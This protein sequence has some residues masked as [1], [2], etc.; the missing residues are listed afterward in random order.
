MRFRHVCIESL[1][2]VLPEESW[3]SDQIEER[4]RPLYER[5][6]LPVGRLELMTGIKARRM[7]PTGMRPSDASAAAGRA[8]LQHSKFKAHEIEAFIHCAVSRDMLEPATASFAHHK[9]GLGPHT[10]IFDLSNACLG[11]LNGL[12]TLGAMI[13][14]GQ[15]RCGMVVSGE[16]GRPL[17]EQTIARLLD[18]LLSRNDIKPFFA[19][20]TIGSGSVA[21]VVCHENLLPAGPKHRL[22]AG[23]V[24]AATQHSELC[25][26]DTSGGGLEM[27]TDSEQLL[28]AGVQV[29]VDTWKLFEAET[30]WNRETPQRF[31]SHQVGNTHRRKL[32]ETLGLDL[33]RDF[34]T[35]EFL[36]NT[37]SAALPTALAL[38]VEEGAVKSGDKVALMGIGSGINSL[39]LALEW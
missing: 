16:N 13:D 21:A 27:Q 39:M 11:F 22:L 18:P 10:Q 28:L 1:R 25:Q 33:R 32:Y 23:A 12:V 37:G 2:T 17:V 36:G 20:L 4:L 29:A 35:F 8:V 30:G 15:I 7:W 9:I 26:G 14:A 5:L 24:L 3:T 31:I 19:N 38:A 6:K 34:S